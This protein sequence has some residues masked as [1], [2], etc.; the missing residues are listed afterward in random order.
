MPENRR[1]DAGERPRAAAEGEIAVDRT[2]G[3]ER[4]RVDYGAV[5]IRGV[6]PHRSPGCAGVA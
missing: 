4:G 3:I 6:G 2:A 5:G 1:D